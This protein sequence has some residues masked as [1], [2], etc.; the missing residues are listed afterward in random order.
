MGWVLMSELD[1]QRIEVLAEVLSA[2]RTGGLGCSRAGDH[3]SAGQ[4]SADLVS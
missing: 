3:R 1:V 4:P 2:Q